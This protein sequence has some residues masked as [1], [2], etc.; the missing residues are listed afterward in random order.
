MT[1]HA[2][3][4]ASASDEAAVIER[5]IGSLLQ[6]DYPGAFSVVLVDDQSSDGTAE[7][8]HRLAG[9]DRLRIVSAPPLPFGWSG[10]LSAMNCGAQEAGD[11]ELILFTDADI[12]HHVTNLRELV[13]R[14]EA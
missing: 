11:A 4:S 8:A 12:A 5:S 13:A 3:R 14:L 10:K 6:Q 7:I 2:V 1:I 9:V